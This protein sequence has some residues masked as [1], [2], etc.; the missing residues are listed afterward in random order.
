MARRPIPTA[1]PTAL[2]D[3]CIEAAREPI[4]E[5]GVEHLGLREVARRLGVSR[6][7]P[8]KH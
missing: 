3:A 1:E 8:Y 2:R 4:A 6:Q 5:R 7:A